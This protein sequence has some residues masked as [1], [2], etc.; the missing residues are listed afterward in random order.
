MLGIGRQSRLI[1]DNL[2]IMVDAEETN[3]RDAASIR[4]TADELTDAEKK[5]AFTEEALRQLEAKVGDTTLATET[6]CASWRHLKTEIGNT[7]D[8]AKAFGSWTAYG[9]C[10]R[11]RCRGWM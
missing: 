5:I 9:H 6:A 10:H 4:K 7:W 3:K 2:G 8:A 11:P 1:L